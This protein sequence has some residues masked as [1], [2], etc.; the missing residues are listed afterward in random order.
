MNL[1]PNTVLDGEAVIWLDG[2]ID[3]GAVRSRASSRG[4]RLA[5]LVHRHPASYAA[6]DCLMLAGQDVRG[7]PYLERRAALLDVLDG[8]PPLQAV[9]ATDDRDVALVWFEQLQ[10]QGIEGIV[11]KRAASPYRGG[12]RV[13]QKVRHSETTDPQWSGTS[14][15]LRGRGGSRSGCLTDA[16]CCPGPCPRRSP[17]RWPDTPRRPGPAGARGWTTET[18]TRR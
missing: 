10:A 15:L 1:P 5:D 4:R 7:L 11:A 6:F 13:F 17:W 14:A 9:P 8:G 16:P 12:V 3:F 2:R 18:N